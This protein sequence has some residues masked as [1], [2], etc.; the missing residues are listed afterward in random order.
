MENASSRILNKIDIFCKL[1]SKYQFY[2]GIISIENLC[3]V[4]QN[5]GSS[6]YKFLDNLLNKIFKFF[7]NDEYFLE[8]ISYNSFIFVI[9]DEN[10]KSSISTIENIINFINK[11]ENFLNMQNVFFLVRVGLAEHINSKDISITHSQAQIALFECSSEKKLYSFYRE[12]LNT[13]QKHINN[14]DL[15]ANY[16]EAYKNRTLEFDFQPIVDSKTRK[17]IL[18]ECLLRLVDKEGSRLSG[19]SCIQAAEQY[20]LISFMD[21]F[22]L[23][24]AIKLLAND[25]NLFLHINISGAT[26]TDHD[27][28]EL[29]QQLFYKKNFHHRL[30]VEITE[31]SVIKNLRAANFFIDML[32]K[33]GCKI[34][35]D[36]FGS[37][38]SSFAQLKNMEVDSIKIGEDYIKE[39]P[40]NKD[41][42]VFIETLVKLAKN[43]NL[44]IIA[45]HVENEKAARYLADI[46]IDYLQ[47]YLFS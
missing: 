27:W 18:Y 15:L 45:E 43:Q 19:S 47:G 29:A 41:N 30:V 3:I 46:G 31:T 9:I 23:S 26:I 5:H 14:T 40:D 13:I 25:K 44:E 39:L 12:S 36:D 24:K 10:L 33:L 32:R 34:S 6:I 28:M 22:T 35:I 37:G 2:I 8:K 20:G 42:V 4:E 17:H 11:R 1:S 21:Q 16:L 38:Y 7:T